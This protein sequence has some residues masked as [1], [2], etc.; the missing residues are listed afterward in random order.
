MLII[1]LLIVNYLTYLI[2]L[3]CENSYMQLVQKDL[4]G[5]IVW[6]WKAINE[7]DR[8]ESALKDM[9][10]VMK[11][12]HRTEEAIEAINSFRPRCSKQ[13]HES[14]DN[15]L[16]DLYKVYLYTHICMHVYMNACIVGVVRKIDRGG[17][18]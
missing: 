1:K 9:V 2:N 3:V 17:A 5:A 16:L 4:E 7:G 8:V 12:L 18:K 14:L 6:F 15:L 10:V 13:A 11:Q